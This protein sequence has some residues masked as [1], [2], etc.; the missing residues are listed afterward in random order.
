MD[1]MVTTNTARRYV[2]PSQRRGVGRRA[3]G[4]GKLRPRCKLP[5]ELTLGSPKPDTTAT[6]PPLAVWGRALSKH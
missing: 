4:S 3:A 5:Y 1:I 2:E 6:M